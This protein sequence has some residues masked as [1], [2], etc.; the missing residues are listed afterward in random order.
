MIEVLLVI[1]AI[2]WLTIM[3]KWVVPAIRMVNEIK[4]KYRDEGYYKWPEN[5]D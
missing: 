2:L 1:A 4:D 3:I 5:W